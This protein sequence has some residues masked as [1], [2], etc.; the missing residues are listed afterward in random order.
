MGKRIRLETILAD[1]FWASVELWLTAAFF[2][3]KLT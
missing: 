3:V 1:R 2:Q